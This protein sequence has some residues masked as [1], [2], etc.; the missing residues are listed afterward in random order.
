MGDPSF[1]VNRDLLPHVHLIS[2]YR[3][4]QK[5]HVEIPEVTNWLMQAPQIARDKAPFFWT[6][7]D[8]PENGTITLTWQ[9]FQQMGT[10]FASDGYIWP[11]AE[12]YFTQEVGNGVILEM[13]L[14]KAGFAYGEQVATHSRRRFRL[15]PPNVHNPN[16]PQVDPSLWIVH[17]GPIDNNERIPVQVLPRDPRTQNILETRAYLQRCGQIQRKEFIL[18]DRV[19]WPQIAWPREPSRQAMYAGNRGVPQTM[20]Y[21]T[22]PPTAGAPPSKRARTAQAAHS[23]VQPVMGAVPQLDAYDDEEDTSR[24]DMFD[25]LTPREISLHRYRQN[26]EWMEEILSSPYRMN[27]IGFTSLALGLRGALSGLTD[28]IFDAEGHEQGAEKKEDRPPPKAATSLDIEQ[29]A[30]FRSRINEHIDS[31]NAEIERMKAEHEKKLSKFRKNSLLTTAEKDL[32]TAIDH[33]TPEALRLEG[34]VE[35]NEDGTARWA[36]KHSKKV[37]DIVSLVEAQFGHRA[38]VIYEL[39]RI[40]DGGYQEPAPEPA[41]EAT[42][43]APSGSGTMSRQ[44]SHTGSH[45]SGMVGDSDMDMGGTAAGLLDQMHTGLSSNSTPANNLPTPQGQLSAMPSYAATPNVSSPHPPAQV[46]P[47]QP[48]TGGAE[49]V[50]MSGT[51]AEPSG[52]PPDQGTGSGDWVVVPKGGVTPELAATGNASASTSEPPKLPTFTADS[53][54]SKQASATG[55][56]AGGGDNASMGFDANDFG[57]L[58]DLDTAGDA[59]AD[60]SNTPG[61]LGGD[62]MDDSAFGDAFHGVEAN[63]NAGTPADGNL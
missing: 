17:Y 38:E 61:D 42:Q 29:A 47:Q 13:Y 40:Q 58:G 54:D 59:L 56:P 34:R 12:Q 57:S 49:D 6:Y 41:P 63:A 36:A 50:N 21:P 11:P 51:D 27:Q 2:T 30:E 52:T 25:H 8:R 9:P 55:T 31:T 23:Q 4:T 14:H 22:H 20:A 53:S 7:L 24:G 60:F 43:P 44:A 35:E 15:C 28:G 46:A 5:A 37:D 62:F 48:K 45:N 10:N 3:Y 19:N 32:R 39:K 33:V 1:G 16:T 26:H 18:S